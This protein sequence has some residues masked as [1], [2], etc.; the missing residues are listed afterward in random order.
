MPCHLQ[1][2]YAV[3]GGG[4]GSLPVTEQ[5]AGEILSLSM[6]PELSGD[7][8]EQVIAGVHAALRAVGD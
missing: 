8:V 3:Y 5:A 7:E 2:A 6:Y 4:P 1:R